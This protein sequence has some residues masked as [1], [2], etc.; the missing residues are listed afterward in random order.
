MARKTYEEVN[1]IKQ[2]YNINTLWSWSRYKT[3]KDD[4]YEYFLKYIL[5]AKE[6]RQNIYSISGGV[7]HDII[8]SYYNGKI[9]Q[10]DMLP[11]Y[12]EELFIMNIAEY[13]YNRNDSDKN[14]KIANKYENC[15][16][17]FFKNHQRPNWSMVCEPHIIIKITDD[18][19]F[20]GYIDNLA[21]DKD[22]TKGKILITDYKTSTIY[23]GEK[24]KK[25]S[26][27]LYLYA[28]GI[29][30]KTGRRLSDII[31][32]YNFI[33]YVAVSILQANGKWTKR[34]IE[35]HIIGESLMSSVK[36]WLKKQG[37]E[38]NDYIDDIVLYNSLDTLPEDVKN[39]FVINDCYMQV[40]I[41]E[42]IINDL[43]SNIIKTVKEI[44]EKTIEYNKTKD[45][46]IF[47]QDVTKES[48]FRLAVLS[49]Y[50]R[51][52]HKP[53]DEYLKDQ[54]IFNTKEKDGADDNDDMDWLNDLQRM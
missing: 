15:V 49:G 42:E 11:K 52:H 54:E 35:R 48:E 45:D 7:C 43:K 51:K 18:I 33:K 31:I 39:K 23:K 1:Q 25:E 32:Q 24:L 13:K 27:Q 9:K 26:G 44:E 2:Q 3:Y 47:W 10:E 5:K 37:Y 4:T 6:D 17:H 8:E 12:E 22:D 53:Y 40:D 38:P 50:S 41:N 29:R 36:M 21:V 19:V 30:Q 46:N 16:K 28:E 34:Y 14:E 20:Q